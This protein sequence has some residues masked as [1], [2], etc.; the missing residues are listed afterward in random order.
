MG[1]RTKVRVVP[2]G[3]E[4]FLPRLASDCQVIGVVQRGWTIGALV[5][6]TDG[7]YAQVNGDIVQPLNASSVE[8]ELRRIAGGRRALG[9]APAAPVITVRRRRKVDLVLAG[10]AA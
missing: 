3:A 5:W 1:S 6:R 8:H 4:R 7:S 2:F 10:T 9:P